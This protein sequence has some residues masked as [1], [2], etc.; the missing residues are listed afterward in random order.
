MN[1]N[2]L[3][4]LRLRSHELRRYNIPSF[5]F[6]YLE[7]TNKLIYFIYNDRNMKFIQDTIS[8]IVSKRYNVKIRSRF[9]DRELRNIAGQELVFEYNRLKDVDFGSSQPIEVKSYSPAMKK[10]IEYRE[11]QRK[12]DK[13]VTDNDIIERV[14]IRIIRRAL[15]IIDFSITTAL[16]EK[17]MSGIDGLGGMKNDENIRAWLQTIPDYTPPIPVVEDTYYSLDIS[18]AFE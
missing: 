15:D 12:L 4:D 1:G 6:N 5:V 3:I 9:N 2:Q 17:K 16:R 14:N 8:K 7:P 10:I 11:L 13:P 18:K